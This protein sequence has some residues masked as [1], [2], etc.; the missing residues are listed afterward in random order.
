MGWKIELHIILL[1]Q[2]EIHM[3]F[4]DLESVRRCRMDDGKI[5]LIGNEGDILHCGY[6]HTLSDGGKR[7]SFRIVFAVLVSLLVTNVIIL[8]LSR[9][10]DIR[11]LIIMLML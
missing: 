2:H 7:W 11:L 6:S 8:Y 1:L 4:S 3:K 5:I 9:F 10:L